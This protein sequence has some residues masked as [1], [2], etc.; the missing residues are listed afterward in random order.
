MR[1]S[2]RREDLTGSDLLSETLLLLSGVVLFIPLLLIV[3]AVFIEP[4]AR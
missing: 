1:R 4:A 3:A 2:I